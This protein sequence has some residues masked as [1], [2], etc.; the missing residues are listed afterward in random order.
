MRPMFLVFPKTPEGHILKKYAERR[1]MDA[2]DKLIIESPGLS[3][4]IRTRLHEVTETT[5]EGR[6]IRYLST[7]RSLGCGIILL[8]LGLI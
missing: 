5:N 7:A 2:D 8:K 3:G 4:L 6:K 1:I